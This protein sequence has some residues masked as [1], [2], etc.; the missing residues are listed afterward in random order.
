MPDLPDANKD[1]IWGTPDGEPEWGP[2]PKKASDSNRLTGTSNIH[3]TDTATVS[4]I[5][6]SERVRAPQLVR[7]LDSANSSENISDHRVSHEAALEQDSTL[8]VEEKNEEASK[9][10]GEEESEDSDQTSEEEDCTLKT[11]ACTM[12]AKITRLAQ[13][14]TIL[15][16]NAN[17]SGPLQERFRAKWHTDAEKEI[18][19]IYDRNCGYDRRTELWEIER[20]FPNLSDDFQTVVAGDIQFWIDE[21]ERRARAEKI[22]YSGTVASGVRTLTRRKNAQEK[23]RVKKKE[24]SKKVRKK[25]RNKATRETRRRVRETP[26]KKAERST[27]RRWE[28]AWPAESLLQRDGIGLLINTWIPSN[29]LNSTFQGLSDTPELQIMFYSRPGT[30][31]K[32]FKDQNEAQKKELAAKQQEIKPCLN[33]EVRGQRGP[34]MLK[35]YP[36]LESWDDFKPRVEKLC[37][38]LWPPQKS[39]KQLVLDALRANKFFGSFVPPPQAPLIERLRGGDYN[40]ITSITLPSPHSKGA[41]KFILRNSRWDEGRADRDVAALTYVGQRTSI[42][43]AEVVAKDFSC[44]NALGKP[45][46]IQSWIPGSDLNSI[47][48]TLSH[49]Q[50]CTVACEMSRTIKT[51]LSLDSPVAGLVEAAPLDIDSDQCPKIVPF[52]LKE[53]D[54][55]LIEE[56]QPGNSMEAPRAR[57]RT[58]DFFK[59]QFGRWRAYALTRLFERDIALSSGLLETVCE[60][61]KLGMF[62][63][64][65]MHCILDWDEAVIAPKF[66]NCQ[67]PWWLWEEEGD[68]REDED[69]WPTWPYELKISTDFPATPDKQELKRLFEENTGPEFMRLAYDDIPRLSRGL[70]ILAKEGLP[71]SEHYKAAERRKKMKEWKEMRQALTQ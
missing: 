29:Q 61:G 52:E 56:L 35:V 1:R 20:D 4:D 14:N 13:L 17:L 12:A 23:G 46:V 32:L 43:V 37:E 41:Q 63:N 26:E 15:I 47:W 7:S 6:P 10:E 18:L 33:V 49:S 57:E 24:A 3:H 67:P 9:D 53:P 64:A 36:P 45:Y 16:I 39:M 21:G 22:R 44:E 59:T 31:L 50:R 58:A 2:Q 65:A 48:D 69:G 62:D 60:M 42:P 28:P 54:G 5:P 71:S 51:L 70:F 11:P 68:K 38:S 40:R 27:R 30:L 55:E 66:V 19:N 25:A 34:W 8:E